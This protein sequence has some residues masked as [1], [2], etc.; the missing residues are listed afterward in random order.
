MQAI[1]KK[2][3]APIL[4]SLVETMIALF[5]S[6]PNNMTLPS[7]DS[8]VFLYVGW[9]VLSGDIP[10]RDA[11][12]HK[13]PLVYFV[14]ALGLF[15]SPQSLL[16][17]WLIQFVIIFLTILFLYKTLDQSLGML[18]AISGTIILTSGILTVIEQGNVTEE[19][20]LVFQVL[21]I[22]LFLKAQ[23]N[24][25]PLITTFWIGLFGG[26]AFYFKQTTIGVWLTLAFIIL[27]TRWKQKRRP[28]VDLVT[29]ITG[30]IILSLLLISYF[31]SH[32]TLS[33]F[34]EQAFL[35]N[36][37]YIG[38]NEGYRRL[39][40]VFTKGFLL[41]SEGGVLYI[42]IAGWIAGLLYLWF[43]RRSSDLEIS[44]LILLAL[45]DFPIEVILI[46]VSGRSII[47]YYLTP[48]PAMAWLAGL[49]V[50]VAPFLLKRF[51][52]YLHLSNTKV[53][54]VI[55]LTI[56]FLQVDQ[57]RNYP[58]YIA[59]TAKND[60]APVIQYV[61]DNTGPEDRVLI[62]GAESVVNFLTRRQ[63]PTR[64]VYQYPLQLLGRR[65]MFEE[66]FQDILKNK[67]KLIISA[68]GSKP[69]NEDLYKPL[70]QRS[71]IV[72]NGVY[73]LIQNYQPVA[74]FGEWIIYKYKGDR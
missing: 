6:N 38:K 53:S 74:T 9:R 28:I 45:I 1:S 61:A 7:R 13:P 58:A 29:L 33:G 31:A 50:Y 46:T 70:Q 8:G 26:S 64:Y 55:L 54:A 2:Y 18:P 11:W 5:P 62:I 43:R 37:V 4:L 44:P 35:Y 14:D 67:P 24:N 27:I 52:S 69:I 40:P 71:A 36:F 23:K 16:G 56:L 20:A 49:L 72:R 48:L 12:D 17:V 19:Y 65:P 32:N 3:A 63:S 25:F 41:L 34:W 60:Y 51:V 10:Y 30:P 42:A 22:W 66:Y 68:P 15:L 57:I 47:H 73:Y 59:S 39:I 21:S